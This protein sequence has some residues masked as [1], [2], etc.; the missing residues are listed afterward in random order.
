ML[1]MLTGQDIGVARERVLVEFNRRLVPGLRAKAI[2]TRRHKLTTYPSR[3]YG[4]LYDH[5]EDRGELVNSRDDPALA[6]AKCKL[7]AGLVD[8]LTESQGQLRPRLAQTE[9]A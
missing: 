4:E 6:G 8:L 5:E 3:L 9:A 2:R 1:P 7:L